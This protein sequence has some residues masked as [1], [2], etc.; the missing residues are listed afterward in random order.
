MQNPTRYLLLMLSLCLCSKEE[1]ERC[2]QKDLLEEML[3]EMTGEFPALSRVFV[4][5]RDIFLANS[6][7]LAAS[8]VRD[9]RSSSGTF[10]NSY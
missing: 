7:R 2:K 9:L 6:L 4:A 10:V 1:V 3:H 8:P 5:E